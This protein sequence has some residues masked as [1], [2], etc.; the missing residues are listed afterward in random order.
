MSTIEHVVEPTTY[1]DLVKVS[2]EVPPD[3]IPGGGTE[4]IWA[5]DLGGGSYR[6][7]NSPFYVKGIS[8]EYIVR[9]KEKED[10]LL[11]SDVAGRGGHSTY[12]LF[13]RDGRSEDDFI[14]A[15]EP[16]EQLGCS[17]EGATKRLLAID[18]PPETNIYEAYKR[19]QDGEAAGIWD[20]QE[21]HCGHPLRQSTELKE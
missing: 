4:I 13:L 10:Q 12:R 18:V 5:E 14:R 9:A 15:W 17:Y 20:F 8:F 7:R 3:S 11:F 21:G 1:C 2:F 16:L 19:L 6:I